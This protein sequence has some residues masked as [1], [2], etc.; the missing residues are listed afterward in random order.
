[1]RI[2]ASNIQLSSAHRFEAQHTVQEQLKVALHPVQDSFAPGARG[3]R[4][5]EKLIKLLKR[6][7]D[8][9][10]KG[11]DDEKVA[12][13]IDR[14]VKRIE[15]RQADGAVR[16]DVKYRRQESYRE[17]EATS[18]RASGSVATADGRQIDFSAAL[19]LARGYART[20]TISLRATGT[21]NPGA[22]PPESAP[23]AASADAAAPPASQQALSLGGSVLGLDA[24]GD[25]QIDVATELVGQSGNGFSDLA[26]Y[27][28]DGNGFIDEGDS[29]FNKLAL[30]DRGANGLT[31]DTLAV[32]G[33]GAIYTGS[34][35]TPY[36][37]TDGSNQTVANL[38]RSGVYLNENGTT[39]IAQQVDV[40]I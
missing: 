30:V 40:L 4:D 38:S 33:V 25:G 5:V 26:Q 7:L 10:S 22:P 16:F 13:K 6:Y 36:R 1:M 18:F 35:S 23:P 37:Y 20:E 39:G 31:A 21:L 11:G 28:E 32:R 3:D 17:V 24:N 14:L 9:R 34:V 2:I 29:V 15:Q 27:D 8:G 19:D 12:D